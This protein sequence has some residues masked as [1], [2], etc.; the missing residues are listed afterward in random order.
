M[1]FES[2]VSI[3]RIFVYVRDIFT[4][5]VNKRINSIWLAAEEL[6]CSV[7]IF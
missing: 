1:Q 6:P 4:I 5:S 7:A 3:S 2:F